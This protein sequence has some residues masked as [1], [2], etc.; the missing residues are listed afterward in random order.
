MGYLSG[1]FKNAVLPNFTHNQ[2][3]PAPGIL[4]RSKDYHS[5]LKCF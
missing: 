3:M 4:V 2:K 1:Q 5:E